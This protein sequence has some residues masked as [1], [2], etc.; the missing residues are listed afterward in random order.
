[1]GRIPAIWRASLIVFCSS[2]GVMVIELIASRILAPF[3]GVSLYTWT[4]IIGIILGGIALGNYLGGK[5]AD[6]HASPALLT[7]IFL[8]GALATIAILPFMKM[9][10]YAGWINDLPLILRLITRIGI[11]F[12]L[13]AVIL[14]MVSPL[15]IKLTLADL[16]RTGGVVGTIY[17]VST[18]GSIVGTFMTGYF[19][20]LWF[21]TRTIV[22]LVAALLILTGILAW[23]SWKVK[24]RW[25]PD[26]KH[27]LT[28]AAIIVVI[29]S[30][31]GLFQY[32]QNWEEAFTKESNYY[33]I[34]VFDEDGIKVLALDHLI[35][36][37]VKVGDPYYL[38]YEYLRMFVEVSAYTIQNNPS[39]RLLHLGGG[40][41]SF[42]RYM[43]TVYP[44]S[45]NEVVEIDPFVT[46]IAHRELGLPEDTR[47]ITHNE[48]AR[49]FLIERKDQLGYD[50]ILGDVFNDASTPFHLTTLE[51]NDLLKANMNPGGVYLVNIID[52]YEQG[53]YMP[54]FISALRQTFKHVYLINGS[55]IWQNV[56][57]STFVIA[58]TDKPIDLS[59]F[60]TFAAK[61]G[62]KPNAYIRDEAGV[63]EYLAGRHPILLTDDHAP[64]DI[65][66]APLFR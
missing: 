50:I 62:S 9:T 22:W 27:I 35:H 8:A 17:A 51:F 53:E 4:S 16:G 45:R 18:V 1:M 63:S 40:G 38:K 52:D 36:S 59:A 11:T 46:E 20:I 58:A 33:A 30:S 57:K 13:P 31:F 37:Y 19:F 47:I 28:W 61:N 3:I 55:G 32:R 34:R 64:T 41:Y 14:S 65:L 43:D 26:F 56:G 44:A 6:R 49:Q 23:F 39:P 2:F 7:A 15:V 5:L 42:P 48:D 24:D 12:L 66:V 25:H 29:G 10:G 21:G 60:Q 54:S